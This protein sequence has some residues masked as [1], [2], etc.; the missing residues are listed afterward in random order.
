M[1][2]RS[3]IV[4]HNM[5]GSRLV[6]DRTL[7]RARETSLKGSGE[8]GYSLVALLAFMTLLALF[9]MA[10]APSLRQQALR[11]REKE[12]IF[13]GEQVADAIRSYYS[14][15]V[16]VLRVAG[17]QALPSSIDQLLE[18]VPVPGGSKKL[19]VLRPSAAHDPLSLDGEWRLIRP[20]SQELIDFQQS[21]MTY[22]GGLIPSPRDPQMTALQQLAVP[23]LTAVLNTGTQDSSSDADISDDSYSGPFVGVASRNKTSSVLYYYDIDHHNRWIFTPLFR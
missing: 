5:F 7:D 8:S 22:S 4:D 21:V 19:Q 18:G 16:G 20:R 9:A 14:Y 13:R 23:Q 6:S 3:E 2:N 11:E 17:D 15:R 12:A 10:A 1:T